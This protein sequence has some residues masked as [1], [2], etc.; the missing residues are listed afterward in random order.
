M[1]TDKHENASSQLRVS[2]IIQT[3]DEWKHE[4]DKIEKLT[5]VENVTR[6]KALRQLLLA[7]RG[8]DDSAAA[9]LERM[10][11]LV[12]EGMIL[13][14]Y[15]KLFHYVFEIIGPRKLI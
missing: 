9:S 3:L 15:L 14:Y 2:A 8:E 7:Y 5:D 12:Q 11:I 6:G 10:A 1:H 4:L 13:Y